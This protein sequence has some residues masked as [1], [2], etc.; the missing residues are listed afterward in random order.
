MSIFNEKWTKEQTQVYVSFCTV[1]Y[2]LYIS[3]E[4]GE[5]KKTYNPCVHLTFSIQGFLFSFFINL[6]IGVSKISNLFWLIL[7]LPIKKKVYPA[8]CDWFYSC[9]KLGYFIL[10]LFLL[11]IFIKHIIKILVYFT[12]F[13][14]FIIKENC[15][16]VM[17]LYISQI[18]ILAHYII[19]NF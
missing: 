15:I 1:F 19:N 10:L 12:Y 7:R 8:P 17:I 14:S 4:T 3:M 13:I 16:L 11:N 6:N 2:A 9:H 5:T 18:C